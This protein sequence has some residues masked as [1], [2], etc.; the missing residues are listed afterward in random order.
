M[1]NGIKLIILIEV[2]VG[3]ADQQIAL[4]EKIQPLVLSEVGCIQYELNKVSGSD[5]K[6]VLTECWESE[7]S[8]AL[9]EQS[10]HMKEADAVTPLFRSGP[11]TVIRLCDL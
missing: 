10:E 11:A 6:F 9:H 5:V 7:Q 4:Y 3:K 8:L 1:K 2:Q